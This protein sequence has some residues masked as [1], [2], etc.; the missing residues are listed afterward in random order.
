M[1]PGVAFDG[2]LAWSMTW[3]PEAFRWIGVTLSQ[4]EKRG[5]KTS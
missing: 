2:K 4:N 1:V 5:Q 3:P